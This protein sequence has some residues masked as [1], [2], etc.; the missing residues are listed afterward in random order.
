MARSGCLA[1]RRPRSVSVPFTRGTPPW[2]QPLLLT[3]PT[4][5]SFSPLHEGDTSV[6]SI[7][8][9]Y[10]ISRHFV[11]VPFTRGTP[12]WQLPPLTILMPVL[13]F[14]PLHEGDTSVADVGAGGQ[15]RDRAFQS[16]S[17]GGHLRGSTRRKRESRCLRCFSPLH[18]GDTS[19]AGAIDSS[20]QIV[21]GFAFQS[22][23]RGGHL[24][25]TVDS[26][27]QR[28][29]ASV[30]VPFTRGTPPWPAGSMASMTGLTCF[31]PL[32]EGDTS[33]ASPRS[34]RD[35][36]GCRFQSPSRGGH[37]RGWT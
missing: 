10:S 4:S 2:R 30:S 17:R 18:E 19:V 8:W 16:P 27:A 24:R 26:C 6:A 9:R 20:L 14:S 36:I 29:T 13:C 34:A 21:M 37:L 11:S 23:S 35:R 15:G 7:R 32:H 12:P 33:V 5:W 22:P 1:V 3:V 25:G 28:G 31:S